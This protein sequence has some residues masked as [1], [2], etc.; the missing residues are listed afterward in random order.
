MRQ[1]I[2]LYFALL[3]LLRYVRLVQLKS[4][5]WN[6]KKKK[7]K[8]KKL[9]NREKHILHNVNEW[10]KNQTETVTNATQCNAMQAMKWERIWDD[11]IAL[12]REQFESIHRQEHEHEHFELEQLKVCTVHTIVTLHTLILRSMKSQEEVF[13]ANTQQLCNDN[14]VNV[15]LCQSLY[16]HFYY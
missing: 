7:F 3:L 11:H 2:C 5:E 9:K 12:N 6:E 8:K 16:C 4:T 10:K 15:S 13:N 14:G 1:T